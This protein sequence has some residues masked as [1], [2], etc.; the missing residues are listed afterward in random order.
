[1]EEKRYK[2]LETY[3]AITQ[4]FCIWWTHNTNTV[5][6]RPRHSL[7]WQSLVCHQGIRVGSWAISGKIRCISRSYTWIGFSLSNAVFRC[8]YHFNNV[9]V[10]RRTNEQ[11]LRTVKESFFSY[12]GRSWNKIAF[13]SGVKGFDGEKKVHDVIWAHFSTSPP[14]TT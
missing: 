12:M 8:L 2:Q 4:H 14:F 9:A 13:R 11:N 6:Q 3:I 1:M 5:L 7:G 10:V